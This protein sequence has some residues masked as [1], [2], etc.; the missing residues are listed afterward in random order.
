MN[1]QKSNMKILVV[2]IDNYPLPELKLYGCKNDVI[3]FQKF[4]STWVNDDLYDLDILYLADKEATYDN[5]TTTFLSHF[6]NLSDGDVGLFYFSGHGSQSPAPEVFWHNT[7]NHKHESLICYD[8]RLPNGKDLLDK[9]IGWMIWKV[10]NKKD[11]NFTVILDACHSGLGTRTDKV[12]IRRSEEHANIRPWITYLGANEYIKEGKKVFI[13]KSNHILLSACH[14]S[15][16]AKEKIID[17]TPRGIFSYGLLEAL[18]KS[19]GRL[20]YSELIKRIHAQVKNLSFQQHPQLELVGQTNSQ[21]LFLKTGL[22]EKQ[23]W[24]MVN[25]DKKLGWIVNAGRFQGIPLCDKKSATEWLIYPIDGADKD[26]GNPDKAVKTIVAHTVLETC[27][28]VDGMA[29]VGI[30]EQFKAVL[31]KI[32]RPKMKVFLS[33]KSDAVLINLINEELEK[34]TSLFIKFVEKEEEADYVVYG[35]ED[36]IFVLKFAE[37]VPVFEPLSGYHSYTVNQLFRNLESIAQWHQVKKLDHPFSQISDE[38]VTLEFFEVLEDTIERAEKQIPDFLTKELV[39]RYQ[40]NPSSYNP[41]ERWEEPMFRL[42]ITNTSPTERALFVNALF[43]GSDFCIDTSLVKNERLEYGKTT[44]FKDEDDST[45]YL[46]LEDDWKT[47]GINEITENFKII[48]S[49]EPLN[50]DDFEQPGLLLPKN[51]RSNVGILEKGKGR[52]NA[53]KYIQKLDWRVFDFSVKIVQPLDSYHIQPNH[54][55]KID[56]FDLKISTPQNFQGKLRLGTSKDARRLNR[57]MNSLPHFANAPFAFSEAKGN[58]PALDILEFEEVEGEDFVSAENPIVVD[59]GKRVNSNNRVIA[60]GFNEEL[61]HLIPIGL[62]DTAAQ[63]QVIIEKLPDFEPSATRTP[64][65]ALKIFFYETVLEKI[66]FENE[67]PILAVAEVADNGEEVTYLKEIE[68]IKDRVAEAKSILI[69]IHG[70]IGNTKEMVQSAKKSRYEEAGT[71]QSIDN[72][73]DLILTFDYENLNTPI[74]ETAKRFKEKLAAV[75][76]YP[77]NEKTI[78]LVAHSMGGLVARWLIEKMEGHLLIDHLIQLGTPNLGSSWSKVQYLAKWLLTVAF[79][80]LSVS[81]PI[82]STLAY[83]GSYAN[84]TQVT[85]EQMH[86]DSPFYKRL[87]DGTAPKIPYT[88]LAGNTQKINLKEKMKSAHFFSK[89]GLFLK[90]QVWHKILDKV[91]FRKANDIAVTVE[92][93]HGL[94]ASEMVENV[95]VLTDH[96]SYFRD[97]ES[98]G[99]LGTV[100]RKLNGN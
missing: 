13:P 49:T 15:E 61:G 44:Y 45:I 68:T 62:S 94:P 66:G 51:T 9:E 79:G 30:Q 89:I 93:I 8:S 80:K 98:L 87:N 69:F 60:Y 22:T 97:E 19:N 41:D 75:G 85:F 92:S 1:Q 33:P 14:E 23:N 81:E 83:L 84:E 54:T 47:W 24:S 64:G 48:I 16:T 53:K 86:P 52:K 56:D 73:Y 7:S 74:E 78:H 57:S 96:I 42:K 28:C 2:G 88:I 35:K 27:T 40:Y 90:H 58:S 50:T 67:Y 39:L 21:Q 82:L 77:N 17:D 38:E 32:D 31:S 99:V 36:L 37:E 65:R 76:I 34:S 70:I 10:T 95:E 43:L 100:I 20:N 59:L 4:L 46:H 11:I 12:R 18:T 25:F 5:I 3:A 91:I 71:F 29:G 6:A 55:T 26:F 63:E 72:Q